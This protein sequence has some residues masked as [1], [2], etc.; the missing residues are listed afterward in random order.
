MS[1]S[2]DPVDALKY[3]A[4]VGREQLT[5]AAELIASADGDDDRSIEQGLD[6]IDMVADDIA[7]ALYPFYGK[8]I[9]GQWVDGSPL[10]QRSMPAYSDGTW[11]L[12]RMEVD[13]RV[14]TRFHRPPGFP[15]LNGRRAS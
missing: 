12:V 5:L 1:F 14:H 15:Q 2:L 7:A 13:G 3:L 4:L 11:P 9:P 10:G 6:L 8:P